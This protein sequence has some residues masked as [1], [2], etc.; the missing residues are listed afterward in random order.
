MNNHIQNN[1]N[2]SFRD[3]IVIAVYHGDFDYV[4]ELMESE[5][6]TTDIFNDIGLMYIPF[7]IYYIPICLK[8]CVASD[9]KGD[10]G[11]IVRNL[12]ENIDKLLEYWHNIY[13][14]DPN[15]KI[16][17]KKYED[18]FFC[19]SDENNID[20]ILGAPVQMF[21]DNNCRM[22][23]LQLYEAVC[24]FQFDK[25][26]ELLED[27]ANPDV[28]L[29]PIGEDN[30]CDT[31][32]CNCI[33]RIERENSFLCS[34]QIYP[35]LKLERSKWYTGNALTDDDIGDIIGWSAHEKMLE[36][37]YAYT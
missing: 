32:F 4:K 10:M 36:L 11:H 34:C 5:E 16:N 30:P 29:L 25:V 37:L 20:N 17:Y 22:I 9:Y 3:K 27:G 7:P 31:E 15:E 13:G 6:F 2:L 23:D 33:D 1:G 28:D 14:I 19:D 35:N 12:R 18:Y 8:V 21:L 26:K 24:K